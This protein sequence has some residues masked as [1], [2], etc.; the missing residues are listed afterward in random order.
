MQ[1]F[2]KTDIFRGICKKTKKNLAERLI[3]APNFIIF[4][5]AAK[6]HFS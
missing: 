5:K 6:I 4:T 1:S 3:L 2:V